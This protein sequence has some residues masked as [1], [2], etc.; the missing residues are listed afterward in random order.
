MATSSRAGGA[1]SGEVPAP[2]A[3]S[4]GRPPGPGGGAAGERRFGAVGSYFLSFNL[5]AFGNGLVAVFLNL[6]FLS[7]YSFLAVLYFQVATYAAELAAY[8][9]SSYL[10][11]TWRPKQL[12][13]LGLALSGFVLADL[14]AASRMVA[15]SFLFGALWGV[16]MGVFYAGNNPMMHDITRRSDRTP[17]VATNGFLNGLVTLVAPASAGALVQFSTFSGVMRYFW[18]FS[19]TGVFLVVSAVVVLGIHGEAERR[20]RDP[21]DAAQRGPTGEFARFR[22]YFALGQVFAIPYG[23][24]LPIYVFQVTGSYVVTGLFASYSIL[25][26]IA[27]NFAFRHGY[28]RD[29]PFALAAVAGIVA[30]SAVLFVPWAAPLNAFLYAGI[31][32]VLATPLGNMVTVEFMDR[33]DRDPTLDRV[34]VWADREVWLGLGRAAVLLVTIALATYWVRTPT[35]LVVLLPILSLYALA[36]LPALRRSDG[37]APRVPAASGAPF[38]TGR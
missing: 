30:S 7:N 14:L 4:P 10:L 12:Y 38:R 32:T 13:V 8:L 36:Y 23:I 17:F 35:G 19:V 9:A 18:D 20:M 37:P 21:G 16:A 6:F 11:P 25:V 22:P 27:A 5:Y 2:G 1:R 15:N 34:R 24:L 31:Y 28:R 26:G 29:G 33:I 3:G